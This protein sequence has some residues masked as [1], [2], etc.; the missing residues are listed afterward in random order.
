MKNLGEIVIQ[1][2]ERGDEEGILSC[3]AVAFEPY[4][5]E[6]TPEAYADTVLDEASLEERLQHM[7]V[8]VAAASEGIVGTIAASL[9]EWRGAFAWH[10]SQ[11]GFGVELGCQRSCFRQSR[12]GWQITDAN[13]SRW[14]RRCRY[15]RP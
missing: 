2:A 12:P 13:A 9:G 15:R 10:G 8:L 6:Y 11:S 7:H 14:I 3:L 4:R 5:A 1:A